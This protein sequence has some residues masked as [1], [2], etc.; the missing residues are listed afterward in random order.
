MSPL[1]MS[2]LLAFMGGSAQETPQAGV[3]FPTGRLLER[4][5]SASTPGHQYALYLPPGF[6]A[7]RPTPILF[8][9][10]PRGRA[11]V[12]ARLFQP[13]AE[14][15]GYILISSYHSASDSAVDPNPQAMQAMWDDA[16]RWF[17]LDENRIYLAGFS[18]TAR[19]ARLL[20]ETTPVITG[21]IGAGAGL[22]RDVRPSPRTRFLYYGAVGDVDYNFHEVDTLSHSLA[23]LNLPHRIARFQG[24]HS[25]MPPDVAMRAVE[26]LE[27]RAMQSGGR[28][29]DAGLVEQ[30][31]AR[32]DAE[33]QALLR[34]G[35]HLDGARRVAAM[36]RDYGGLR[37]TTAAAAAAAQ[38]LA[39]P[40][41]QDLLNRRKAHARRSDEWIHSGM[42]AIARAFPPG[43]SG[44][45]VEVQ[46]LAAALELATLKQ[47]AATAG[48]DAALEAQRRLNQ[49]EV[50]L[51]FYLPE[52]ALAKADY[53]RAGYYLT[54]AMQINDRSPVSWYLMAQRSA[55]LE[56]PHQ[57]LTALRR[58]FDAGFRD[59]ALLEADPAFRALRTDPGYTAFITLLQSAGD[60]LDPPTV[61]RPPVP[62]RR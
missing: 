28:T 29:I 44:P 10:D 19:T 52:E 6:D 51:G 41:A 58:A 17:T 24:P 42:L 26:W 7:A 33:A 1:V 45:A 18:G 3:A 50:Q 9:M 5:P 62:L 60:V 12:P 40:Q 31:W 25:W 35:H 20:A 54:L 2:L 38:M 53:A 47:T 27:L 34:T 11:R 49:L 37:D 61:D 15:F 14:R 8:L 39:S 23:A 46:D 55:R 48:H 57:A 13:A 43:Q 22:H 32:D 30:W 59:L 56:A 36:A 4:V 21:I 16:T